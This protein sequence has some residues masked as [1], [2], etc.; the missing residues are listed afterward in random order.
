M[1]QATLIFHLRTCKNMF[2]DLSDFISSY[3]TIMYMFYTCVYFNF[4]QKELVKT[5]IYRF[6]FC[7]SPYMY[8]YG[9][10]AIISFDFRNG[11]KWFMYFLIGHCMGTVLREYLPYATFSLRS[12]EGLHI[13][14]LTV[15]NYCVLVCHCIS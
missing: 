7:F 4:R 11:E 6:M 2:T 9:I 13:T 8:K 14:V 15:C 5:I 3:N 10:R 1:R 12:L